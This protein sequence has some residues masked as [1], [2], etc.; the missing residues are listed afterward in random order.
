MRVTNGILT[1]A[2]HVKGWEPAV[3][4]IQNELHELHESKF[5]F[6][7]EYIHFKFRNFLLMYKGLL[8][9]R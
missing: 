2:N 8:C 3:Y 4:M 7:F 5:R 1:L 9:R 6:V